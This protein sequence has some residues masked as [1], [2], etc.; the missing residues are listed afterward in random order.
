MR[1]IG[2]ESELLS[3]ISK[4]DP[5]LPLAFDRIVVHFFCSLYLNLMNTNIV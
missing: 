2:N 1:K 4:D 5:H 3:S